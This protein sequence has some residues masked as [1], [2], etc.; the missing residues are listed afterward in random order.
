MRKTLVICLLVSSVLVILYGFG[1]YR[2]LQ[3]PY[4]YTGADVSTCAQCHGNLNSGGGTISA[5]GLPVAGYM[6]GQAY[7]FNILVSHPELRGR[8]GFAIT[9]RDA[10]NAAVG[11]F[12]TTNPNA[13][14]MIDELSHLNAVFQSGTSFSYNNLRW[15]APANPT[16]AQQTVKFS[17][18]GNA[19]NGDG[20]TGG[21]FIYSGTANSTMVTP[22]NQPPVVSI[23]SPANN[24]I[25]PAGGEV[26]L[27]A[28]ASDPDG[29][30]TKVEFYDHGIKFLTDNTAPY[31]Y[32]S[33]NEIEPGNYLV[34]AK[35]FDNNGDS[36]LSD[37]VHITVTSCTPAGFATGEG[38][39]NIPGTQVADLVNHPSYPSN[40]G[41]TADLTSLEYSNVGD[42]YGGRLRGYICAP[43]TGNYTFY[44]AGD[45]QAGLFLSTDANPGSKVLIAYN[46]TPVAFREWT[47]FTTQRSVPIKL[48]KG[49]RYY[50]ETLHKQSTGQN[51]LSV[52]WV[53]PNAVSESPIP[54]SRLSPFESEQLL[55][56]NRKK[57][58][59]F[60]FFTETAALGLTVEAM[61][62]PSTAY[63]IIK[64]KSNDKK[65]VLI[66]VFDVAGKLMQTTTSKPGASL[67]VG[68]NL[69][70]GIYF[71]E[72]TQGTA[73]QRM[74][75]VK[76]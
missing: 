19:A 63:F 64:S 26:V 70:P 4:N 55:T 50:F 13:A 49:A 69:K 7:D 8:W 62:N 37:T 44:I 22:S 17:F 46:L 68:S 6:K 56:M 60:R 35:A 20:G 34:T 75:L 12:T 5:P 73:K 14:L 67:M 18:I 25:I 10:N 23:S 36:T 41:I 47:R 54:G 39:L 9:A 21:D 58:Q 27:T 2:S 38:Y 3:P 33:N 51:H 76:Q 74:K 30:I 24:I 15:T 72:A 52:R 66:R 42:N 40:P 45:D 53:M 1:V 71:L 43:A 61:P 28:N 48:V 32:T 59:E 57:Q 11:T 29:N 31:T 65:P 16:I